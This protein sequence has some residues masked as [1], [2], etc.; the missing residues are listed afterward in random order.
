MSAPRCP[1]CKGKMAR[2]GKS[3]AGSQ[4]W[5]CKECKATSTN[6][7]DNSA[8]R[9][10]EF[11]DWLLS[12]QRM[13]DMPGGGRTFRRRTKDFWSIW[14]LAPLVD[15]IH[16]VVYVDGIH[17]GRKAVVLIA[18]SDERVLGW[19]LA[20]EE[21]SRAWEALM[22]R[23]APPL[24]VVTDG[25]SG[26]ESARKRVWPQTKVQRCIY[27]A[28][29]QVKRYTTSRPKLQA[30]VELYGI[31]KALFNIKSN[32][33]ASYWL[34][35][36]LKWCEKWE[37]F[38]AETTIIDGRKELT[39]ERLVKAKKSL[40]KLISSHRLFTH[41]DE[42]LTLDGPMPATNNRI[43][44]GVNSPIRQMLREHRGM[45][46]MRRIKA[47]FWWCYMNCDYRLSPAQ[48]LKVMP[49][50]DEITEIYN[51]LTRTEELAGSIPQWGDAI[52]W[53][54]LHMIDYSHQS[55]R[56]DWD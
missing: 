27:H 23:I 53:S 31:A 3:A 25:G 10:N 38:L 8:K 1:I 26:F 2:N 52:M 30:G 41:L 50:D 22:R 34:A 42:S 7:I 24:M 51:Q 4:R 33:D 55:F 56:H 35:D 16:R 39:H 13:A 43:E 12:K 5:K 45:S 14:P 29:C 46:L 36:Y 11:L 6:K 20:R 37:E 47:V 54:E 32:N 21:N 44:G 19:Y 28:F 49:T 18:C 48:T 15:E 17:L 9:L 40:D